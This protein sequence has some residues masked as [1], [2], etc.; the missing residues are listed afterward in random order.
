MLVKLQ[1]TS[2]FKQT[3]GQRS[4]QCG[5]VYLTLWD[6]TVQKVCTVQFQMYFRQEYIP[7][8]KNVGKNDVT[9]L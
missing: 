3:A 1:K 7:L 2:T 5:K 8:K 9:Q 4:K 6:G